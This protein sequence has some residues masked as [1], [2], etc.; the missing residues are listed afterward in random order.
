MNEKR[1]RL[2][3]FWSQAGADFGRR[4][5]GEPAA[6]PLTVEPPLPRQHPRGSPFAP[7]SSPGTGRAHARL[8]R[9]ARRRPQRDAR[10]D[11]E[12]L[13]QSGG[14]MAP[15]QAR[16]RHATREEAGREKFKS[17]AEA[18][19]R[20]RT[21]RLLRPPPSAL[22]PHRMQGQSGTVPRSLRR[23]TRRSPTPTRS[24]C[25]TDTARRDSSAAA[26]VTIQGG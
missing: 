11:Q 13:S 18:R 12:G 9:P 10:G 17:I 7:R 16:E 6:A 5:S 2:K 1:R 15:R 24:R 21:L 26:A 14:Q 19:P 4:Q 8:L 3:G 23:R 22:R 25:T 20:R